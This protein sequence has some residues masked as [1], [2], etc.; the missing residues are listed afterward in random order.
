[1]SVKLS[2]YFGIHL[3]KNLQHSQMKPV[4]Q[5]PYEDLVIFFC[6]GRK[7][8]QSYFSWVGF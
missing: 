7:Q 6:V 5:H 8:N 3:Q 4:L 2:L 1:M